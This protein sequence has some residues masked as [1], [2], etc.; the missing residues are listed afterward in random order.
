MPGLVAAPERAAALAQAAT[1]VTHLVSRPPIDWLGWVLRLPLVARVQAFFERLAQRPRL[2]FEGAFVGTLA[3]VLVIG[4][5]TAG[6]ADL[7]SLLVAEVRQERLE[8]QS[9]IAENFERATEAGRTVWSSS[10]DRLGERLG[11]YVDFRPDTAGTRSR[12]A[13]M[14][15]RWRQAGVEVATHLWEGDFSAAFARIWH[16][17]TAPWRGDGSEEGGPGIGAD[18]QDAQRYQSQRYQSQR[19][20][21]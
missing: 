1:P 7:P 19:Y 12:L 9:A 6:V 15:G 16:L 21:S 18:Y 14:L 2:A 8:V 5:P 17:W 10:K 11:A 4:V 3:F 20:Q 13:D